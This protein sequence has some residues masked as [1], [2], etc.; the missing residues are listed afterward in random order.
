MN[1][2]RTVRPTRFQCLLA[3]IV[4]TA[5]VVMAGCGGG[6][7]SASAD[8]PGPE[9]VHGL[10]IN[11]A[12]SALYIATHT[13][14]FRM[15]R[16][17]ESA[18][19]VGDRFQDTMGFAVVGPDHFL[20]SGHPDLRDELPPLLG[21]IESRDA[22]RSWRP[23]SLLGD[24]D[25]HALRSSG[26][27]VRGYDASGGRLMTSQDAGRSWTEHAPPEALIDVVV[28]PA[29]PQ[30]IV[31][32]GASGLHMSGD[33]G[34][35]WRALPGEAALLAWPV[36]DRLYAVG[37]DGDVRVSGDGGRSWSALEEVPGEPAAV[38]APD[39][40]TLIVALHDGAFVST[41]DGGRTWGD[42]PWS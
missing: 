22:G 5:A 10:G 30:R 4:A 26:D 25:F 19:R 36:P 16:G 34:R 1:G 6:G 21:L 41:S 9:H 29:D 15:E 24:A 35:S 28:D 31:A 11:P 17:S 23:I 37:L 14:L 27:H 40:R 12:D 42:G 38:T 7:P 8:G 33:G 39:T 32:A 20:G 3:A 2:D 18:K 13:G